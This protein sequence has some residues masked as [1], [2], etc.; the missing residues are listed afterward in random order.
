MTSAGNLEWMISNFLSDNELIGIKGNVYDYCNKIV[1]SLTAQECSVIFLPFLFGTNVNPDAKAC[2]IGIDGSQKTAHM[3]RAIY[4][5]VVFSHMMHIEKL[6]E[7]RDKP[8]AVRISGGAT[9][10]KVWVQMFADVLQLPI[11]VSAAKELGTLGCA[12]CVGVA[13]GDYNDLNSA[14]DKMARVA[15]TCKPNKD[16]AL[17]YRKKYAIYKQLIETLDST[18]QMWRDY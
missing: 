9:E 16:N 3:I 1:G 5:G 11:E 15:Y 7:F 4:E 6:L 2:F 12:M 17:V 13:A 18:W 10:S 8:E 14:A